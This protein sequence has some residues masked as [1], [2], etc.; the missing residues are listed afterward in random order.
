[1]KLP[2][3]K[4]PALVCSLALCCAQFVHG[5]VVDL[6]IIAGQSNANG[7]GRVNSNNGGPG[8]PAGE[9][10]QDAMFFSSWHTFINNATDL[11]LSPINHSG[12][13]T[14]VLSGAPTLVGGT[15]YRYA[16]T[17][18]FAEGSARSAATPI[19]TMNNGAG[20]G[21]LS[22]IGSASFGAGTY[23]SGKSWDWSNAT[24]TATGPNNLSGSCVE[25]FHHGFNGETGLADQIC[26]I[27]EY[28]GKSLSLYE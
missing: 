25:W 15:T 28:G 12:H 13:T 18:S 10:T 6:F 7:Q 21:S 14:A 11:T 8:L 3:L 22:S 16:F 1:M 26:L 23:R 27:R 4:L 2:H 9:G 17:G 24:P 19:E 5:A 20:F